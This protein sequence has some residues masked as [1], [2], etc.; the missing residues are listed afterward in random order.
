MTASLDPKDTAALASVPVPDFRPEDETTAKAVDQT[1]TA[2]ASSKD[3]DIKVPAADI[4][5]S[6]IAALAAQTSAA[7]KADDTTDE[8]EADAI[9]D[10][11]DNADSND[12]QGHMAEMA[13]LDV[14]NNT[15]SLTRSFVL[16]ANVAGDIKDQQAETKT[17]VKAGRKLDAEQIVKHARLTKN[18]IAQWAMAKGRLELTQKPVKMQRVA[19]RIAPIQQAD[20]AQGD[21]VQ[22]DPGRF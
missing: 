3:D 11:L 17:V 21:T 22:I 7:A 19:T 4:K 20:E 2:T 14:P 1:V 13:S 12:Q 18:L 5:P 8:D 10:T 15:R 6:E 9:T 16:P